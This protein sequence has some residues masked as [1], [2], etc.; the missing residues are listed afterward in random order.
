MKLLP[1]SHDSAVELVLAGMTDPTTERK[2]V[3]SLMYSKPE[4]IHLGDAARLIQGSKIVPGEGEQGNAVPDC[5]F[6]D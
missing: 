5:E 3:L 4:L 6:D 1:T 2:E